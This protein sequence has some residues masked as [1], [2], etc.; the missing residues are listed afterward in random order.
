M[1][2]KHLHYFWTVARLGGVLKAAEHLHVTP[3]TI[4]GQIHLLEEQFGASL[5]CKRGRGL[6][7][8]PAGELALRYAQ[9]IFNAGAELQQLMKD[10][11]QREGV[12]E[13]KVGVADAV[14]KMVACRVLEPALG[15]MP[16]V[17]VVVREWKLDSLLAEL[18]VHRLD[19]VLSDRPVPAGLSVQAYTHKLGHSALSFH[20]APALARR[21]RRG[22]PGSLDGEPL[23]MPARESALGAQLL[24]WLERQGIRPLLVGEFDD[25]AMIQALGAAGHG[26]FVAPSVLEGEVTTRYRTPVIGRADDVSEEFYLITVSRRLVHPG[27]QAIVRGAREDL[28]AKRPVQP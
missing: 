4:S 25:A 3:Q 2:Y 21:L 7:L 23:L 19:L 17:K 20:A 12:Q 22:F 1:N 27:V 8:T 5:L 28:F 26:V 6:A 15:L 16:R 10:P 14:P 11:D 18:A 13:L 24:A 9:D